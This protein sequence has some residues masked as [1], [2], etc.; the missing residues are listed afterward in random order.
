MGQRMAGVST[1]QR[2]E[3]RGGGGPSSSTGRTPIGPD[4]REPRVFLADRGAL[5]TVLLIASAMLLAAAIAMSLNWLALVSV[6]GGGS[7][8]TVIRGVEFPDRLVICIDRS[9]SMSEGGSPSYARAVHEAIAI[10]SQVADD[11][12]VLFATFAV[13]VE[14]DPDG[15]IKLPDAERLKLAEGWLLSQS[16]AGGTDL[17][18]PVRRACLEE[19]G[20]ALGIIVLTDGDPDGSSAEEAREVARVAANRDPAAVVGALVI[21]P[22]GPKEDSFGL[23]VGSDGKGGYVRVRSPKSPSEREALR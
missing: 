17:V 7:R 6:G 5:R 18:A 1:S 13:D 22:R 20:K 19:A 21:D 12:R 23:I 2:R 3:G 8:K 14:V 11:G 9:A 4:G 16:P 15:W 10:A